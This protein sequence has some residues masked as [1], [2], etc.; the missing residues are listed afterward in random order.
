MSGF[1]YVANSLPC[2]IAINAVLW[3]FFIIF[4]IKEIKR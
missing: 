1:D 3:I 4:I 2:I